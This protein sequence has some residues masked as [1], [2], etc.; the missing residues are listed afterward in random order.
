MDPSDHRPPERLR[1]LP[2]WLLGRAA[3]AGDRL[4]SATLAEAGLRTHHFTALLAI[5]ELDGLSQ[6]ELG[7]RLGLDVS[8]V[9][10]VVTELEEQG[11]V[12]R[13]RDPADRRRNVLTLTARGRRRLAGLERRVAAAQDALLDPLSPT[14][15]QRLVSALRTLAES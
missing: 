3:L 4:V 15:R 8:D 7:R 9:H 6:A 12:A 5:A 11:S 14:A 13:R 10:A 1:T 2:T